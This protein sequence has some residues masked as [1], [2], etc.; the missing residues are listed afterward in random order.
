MGN[1]KPTTPKRPKWVFWE[2][3]T[4]KQNGVYVWEGA[5][6]KPW[7]FKLMREY[8]CE[9]RASEPT[10]QLIREVVLEHFAQM[11]SHYGDYG[12]ILFRK[13]LHTYSKVG[14]MG[15]TTISRCCKSN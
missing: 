4:P 15:A 3:P 13:H 12:V 14:Y 6:G 7:I 2:L 1:N 8:I 9:G 10:P 11:V 5:V